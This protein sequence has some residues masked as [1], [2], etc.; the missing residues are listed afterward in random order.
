MLNIDKDQ[1]GVKIYSY[2]KLDQ[3]RMAHQT[4]K[5]L[6]EKVS[7]ALKETCEN[8]KE[9]ICNYARGRWDKCKILLD[10]GY[11]IKRPVALKYEQMNEYK[12]HADEIANYMDLRE[13]KKGVFAK[14]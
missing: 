8:C 12:C 13:C 9:S 6:E 14:K 7:K 11:K 2:W 1:H 10:V 3:I 5:S 4:T